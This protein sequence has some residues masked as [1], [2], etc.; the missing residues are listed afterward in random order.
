MRNTPSTR[1]VLDYLATHDA[2]DNYGLNIIKATG[3]QPGTVYP[4]LQRLMRDGLA[5]SQWEH[6]DA[7]EEGRPKRR[8]Y[9]LTA[10]GRELNAQYRADWARQRFERKGARRWLPW[11]SNPPPEVIQQ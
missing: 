2:A 5:V 7:S 1:S 9:Q 11:L 3:F 6:I 10:Q 4:I 8:F